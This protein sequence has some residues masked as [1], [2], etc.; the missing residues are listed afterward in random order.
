MRYCLFI[1]FIVIAVL[2]SSSQP[3]KIVIKA[4]ESIDVLNSYIYQYP[5]FVDG[6]VYYNDGKAASGKMNLNLFSGTMQFINVGGD[7]LAI[8]EEHLKLVVIG[9]DSFHYDGQN[10]LQLLTASP[11]MRLAVLQRLKLLDE[12]N[13]GAYGISGSTHSIDNYNTLRANNTH[14]LQLNKDLIFTSQRQYYFSHGAADFLPAT[15]RNITKAFFKQKKEIEN[16]FKQNDVDLNHEDGVRKL[17]AQFL[18]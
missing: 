17:F 15:K 5:E 9:E 11:S 3:T 13:T 16:Y 14:K 4:G 7:T 1:I 18:K 12:Q 2:R 6:K 10:Y 8:I